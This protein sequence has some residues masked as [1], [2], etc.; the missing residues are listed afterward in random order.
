MG[1]TADIAAA[2]PPPPPKE[3]QSASSTEESIRRV[4]DDF[5]AMR[6]KCG[7]AGSI[8]YEKFRAR[9]EKSRATVLEKHH[10]LDVN[11][12]VY[13]KNGRAALKATPVT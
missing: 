2:A 3:V 4:Y 6:L 12:K 7:E 10:C 13:E 11:F 5:V 9:L 1:L 8:P